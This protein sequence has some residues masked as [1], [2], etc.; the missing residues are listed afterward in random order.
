MENQKSNSNLKAI[1]IVLLVLLLGSLGY[2]FK[3][4]TLDS[5]YQNNFSLKLTYPSQRSN[6]F[7]NK[8]FKINSKT[9]K[10]INNMPFS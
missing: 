6:S 8:D 10:I 2:I 5:V 4:S 7:Y 9:S 3:M 1:V